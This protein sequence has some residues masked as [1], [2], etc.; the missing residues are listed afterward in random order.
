MQIPKNSAIIALHKLHAPN[1]QAFDIVYTHCR[2]VCDIALD[3]AQRSTL[4]LDMDVVRAG[5]LL[6]D[7]GYYPLFEAS[8]YVPK[9]KTI[10]H[11]VVGA[12]LLRNAGLPEPLARIAERHTGVGLTKEYIARV[13]LP[14]PVR[15]LVPETPEEWLILYADKFHTKHISPTESHDRPG[16]F[17]TAESYFAHAAQYGEDN[18]ARFA[19]LVDRYGVPDLRRLS[20]RYEQLIT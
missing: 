4:A 3:L 12:E 13:G 10:T 5:A 14:L 6:H 7:V 17:V 1:V 2:I 9:D 8:G 19:A 20:E 16:T 15:D 18:A 11:G